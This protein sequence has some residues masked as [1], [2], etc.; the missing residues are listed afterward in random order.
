MFPPAA[1]AP[2]LVNHCLKR[3]GHGNRRGLTRITAGRGS[4]T[5]GAKEGDW[6]GGA[7]RNQFPEERLP[8]VA[9]SESGG[10]RSQGNAK[11]CKVFHTLSAAFPPHLR[12]SWTIPRPLQSPACGKCLG[13]LK[14]LFIQAPW[15]LRGTCGAAGLSLA[16]LDQRPC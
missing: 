14:S 12:R 4:G 16:V 5:V 1:L 13:H 6:E 10:G 3:G 7:L 9:I 11:E 8:L 15:V 2:L